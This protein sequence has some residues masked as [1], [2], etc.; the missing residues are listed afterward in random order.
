VAS[1]SQEKANTFA[2]RHGAANKQECAQLVEAAGI[3]LTMDERKWLT[4][5]CPVG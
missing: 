2:E 3:R 4:D 5:G 1:R